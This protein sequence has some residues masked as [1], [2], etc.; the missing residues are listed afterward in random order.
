MWPCWCTGT[1]SC[2]QCTSAGT[3]A[4]MAAL[5]RHCGAA[6]PT[7]LRRRAG[8]SRGGGD[9]RGGGGRPWAA[10]DRGLSSHTVEDAR[11]TLYYPTQLHVPYEYTISSSVH[12]VT[13]LAKAPL[14]LPLPLPLLLP[15]PL[16][17]LLLPF[18]LPLPPLPIASPLSSMPH[19]HARGSRIARQEF[20]H[21]HRHRRQRESGSWGCARA[22]CTRCTHA[23]A[24]GPQGGRAVVPLVGSQ[25]KLWSGASA[26][27]LRSPILAQGPP[28]SEP[29]REAT[30][31]EVRAST[32][33][34][35]RTARNA[36]GT[37]RAAEP[38]TAHLR[39][40]VAPARPSHLH[41]VLC[42]QKRLELC[43]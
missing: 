16:P 24:R 30:R 39:L 32:Q 2:N 33:W 19:A 38:L 12:T 14:P 9:E 25:H 41:G 13:N 15:L 42:S 23:R 29:R 36:R 43:M 17:S 20:V 31:N 3:A 35:F 34:P 5:A 6:R 1:W 18:T 10:R 40:P 4:T 26:V 7:T 22:A 21:R 8:A 11:D 28:N 27:E 37:V